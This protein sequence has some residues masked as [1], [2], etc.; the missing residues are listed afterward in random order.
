MS[1][2]LYYGEGQPTGIY[3]V[4]PT[5]TF[6]PGTIATLTVLGTEVVA[7]VCDGATMFPYGIFDDIKA[8]AYWQPSYGETVDVTD[9]GDDGAGHTAVDAIGFLVHSNIFESSFTSD[10][11]V[12]LRAINGAILVPAGTDLNY[13]SDDDGIVDSVRVTVS[14]MYEVTD[15]PGDDSTMASGRATIWIT[16]GEY[17]TD[18]Y[19]TTVA[20][21]VMGNLY[22]GTG[23]MKGKF[24]SVAPSEAA[25]AMAICTGPPSS[26]DSFLNFMWL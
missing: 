1:L 22:C 18:Q 20:Y 24:T 11:V 17:A 9:G 5:A 26:F 23:D 19:D 2:R 15:V 14:Y 21:T 10:A 8:T 7:S 25:P 16:R 3:P 12:T 6:Y 4:D 13:D